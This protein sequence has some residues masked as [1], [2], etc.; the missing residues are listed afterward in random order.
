MSRFYGF[1][2]IARHPVEPHVRR[3]RDKAADEAAFALSSA[4]ANVGR[5]VLL[6]VATVVIPV[7]AVASLTLMFAH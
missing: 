5:G 2:Y 3:S 7:I 1:Y 6:L 4:Q